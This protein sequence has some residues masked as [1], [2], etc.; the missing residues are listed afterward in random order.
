MAIVHQ[1]NKSTG[2]VYVYESESYWDKEKQQSRS[3]RRCI[4]KL[5]PATGK[6]I[7]SKKYLAEKELESLKKRGPVASV[8]SKR[9]FYGATYLFDQISENLG[10]GPDL[11]FC[12]GEKAKMIM[13]LAYYLILEDSNAMSRFSKWGKTH[14]HPYGRDFPSQ[15]ISELFASIDENAKQEFFK[16]QG[17]RRDE[18]EFLAYD[19]T[20]ISSY[21]KLIKQVKWGK[22]RDDD[23]LA[24]INLALIY[25][26]KSRLPVYYRKLPGNIADV[27][28]INKLIKDIEFLELGKFMLIM[29]RGFFSKANINALYEKHYKFLIGAKIGNSF[30]QK[31]LALVRETM[32]TRAH[33]SSD[34]EVNYYTKP[35]AWRY[36][37]KKKNGEIV[38][39][40]KRMYL[41]IFYNH[42][43]AA[44][45]QI[46]FN[47]KM[48][49]LEEELLSGKRV[50]DNEKLYE[51]YYH[52][53]ST[54][55][56]G[57][58]LIPKQAAMDEA[59]KNYGYY[60]FV[61][62]KE[63]DPL[64]AL[65]IYRSK[66]IIEKAFE[67][68]KERLNARRTTVSSE[69]NLEGKLFVQF[70][71]LMI[72]AYIDKVMR[73]N[74]LYKKYTL[75]GLLDELDIIERFE[76]PGKR[77]HVGE[78]TQKQSLIYEAMNVEPPK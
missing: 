37:G 66:D 10:I 45:D 71:S 47:K 74:K 70:V 17:S 38:T 15:R 52:I 72:L 44:E 21:S 24:Q 34:L 12:F 58:K 51:K 22:N 54:P 31:E 32:K 19:S 67:N 33:Y 46:A 69:E 30:V 41:H 35:I 61:S 2:V 28:T 27:T 4:G 8:E 68:L 16:Q 11:E 62:N 48:D 36:Q 1:E 78:I 65:Q 5:E 60:V 26:Q 56:K 76:R 43:R 77:H 7:Y 73:D 25:G 23:L 39:S 6:I 75:K 18:N 14:F 55:K 9:L 20:S 57:I 64:A 13:S 53:N 59:Q 29:D 3:K 42:Q 63:K 49:Q 50:K 40:D